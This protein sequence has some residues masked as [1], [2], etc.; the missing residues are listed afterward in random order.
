MVAVPER[1]WQELDAVT[2]GC[3]GENDYEDAPERYSIVAD[4]EARNLTPLV[5]DELEDC[6]GRPWCWDDMSLRR[7]W[8]TVLARSGRLDRYDP[9]AVYMGGRPHTIT[10]DGTRYEY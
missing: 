2:A 5:L 4:I 7:A 10:V 9:D 3:W 1:I 8:L 6:L